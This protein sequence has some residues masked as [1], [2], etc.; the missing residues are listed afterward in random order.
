MDPLA[1][2][3]G[4][5]GSGLT[6]DETESIFVLVDH[7]VDSAIAQHDIGIIIKEI[8]QLRVGARIVGM[9]LVRVLGRI[10]ENWEA[11]GINEPMRDYIYAETGLLAVTVDRYVNVYRMLQLAPPPVA[12]VL[13]HRNVKELIPIG[14]MIA[15]GWQLEDA[16]WKEVADAETYSNI[17]EIT[18]RLKNQPPRKSGLVLWMERE[19]GAVFAFHDNERHYVGTM[20]INSDDPIVK[21][22]I[23]R[24]CKNGGVLSQ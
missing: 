3:D 13:E 19:S 1:V 15:Q 10:A 5:E 4:G 8:A 9:S 20:D 14:N 11:F 7:K 21:K 12:A 18:R 6:K 2:I 23:E 17:T 24:L 22:A 16:E